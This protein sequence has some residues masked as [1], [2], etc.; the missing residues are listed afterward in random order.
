MVNTCA[1]GR[2]KITVQ[3]KPSY[4][5][6]CDCTLCRKSGAAWGYFK[7]AEVEVDG[8]TAAFSREDKSL[9]IVEIHSCVVCGATT[10]FLITEA[11]R[12]ENPKVDQIGVNMRLFDIEQLIDVE[13]EY[14]NGKDWS[15]EGKFGFRRQSRTLKP[16]ATW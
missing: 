6:D 9:P 15:G 8:K 2:V 13:I 7:T 4:I 1:C 14:P 12:E 3:H 11:Y 5:Y 10:H 16:G